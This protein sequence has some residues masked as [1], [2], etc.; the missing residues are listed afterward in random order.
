MTPKMTSASRSASHLFPFQHH[1][2]EF[3]L[4]IGSSGCFLSTG[5]GKTEIFL[6][7]C[8]KVIE[9]TNEKALILTPLAVAAQTKRRAERWGYEARVIRRQSEVG[10]G[11][12]ICNYDRLHNLDP[13]EFGIVVLDEASILK[14]FNGKVSRALIDA[15]RG[16][17]F[18]LAATATPA[19]N[20]HMELGQYCDFLDVMASNEML[21]RWFIA[22][23]NEAGKYRLKRHAVDPFW[24][25][26]SSWARMA[27]KPSDLGDDDSNF[28]LPSYTVTRHRA[29]DSAISREFGS[30]FGIA[31]I[32]ATNLHDI[33]RD[34]IGAR[35]DLTAE[36]VG[37][38]KEEPWLIWVDTN[39]EADAVKA[40][41]PQATEVR[42]S[43]PIEAKEEKLEAFALGKRHIL[44]G[45]PSQLGF[46]LD[47]AH[48]ARM[49]FV[50]RSF[51]YEQFYQAIRRCWRYGQKRELQVHIIVAEG[52]AEIG[53]VIERKSDDHTKMRAAMR[54]AMRRNLEK[55]HGIRLSYNPTHIARLPSWLALGV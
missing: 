42:G 28:D 38:E 3:S 30:L 11:I 46:G 44:I 8:Q 54:A 21:T 27:E 32:S 24:D 2:V 53:R 10:P 7:W 13:T 5:L 14:S 26:V 37:R 20:D 25:W 12:N 35:S 36:I 18:K 16:Y 15:F 51:S 29:R 40:A 1:S 4:R 39:Y 55:V 43:E 23:Q 22:D 50:G 9:A 47:W 33:K 48:C 19:P 34:T 31:D 52:E 49:L 17:R 45:K 6:E 41:I